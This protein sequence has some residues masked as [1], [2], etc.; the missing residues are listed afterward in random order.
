MSSGVYAL[1]AK[2]K[3]ATSAFRKRSPKN[4]PR[5]IFMTASE[6]LRPQRFDGIHHTGAAGGEITG[7]E[8]D[9]GERD[10]R[11]DQ[12]DGIERTDAVEQA[13]ERAARGKGTD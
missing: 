12:R 9:N 10:E 8:R 4:L 6:L 7:D 1:S 3:P 13:V 5:E 2:V 11:A